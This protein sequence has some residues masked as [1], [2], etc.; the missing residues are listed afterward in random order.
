MVRCG[1]S[2]DL[3]TSD[4]INIDEDAGPLR[5]AISTV[6]LNR[7]KERFEKQCLRYLYVLVSC[8]TRRLA[9]LYKRSLRFFC[10]LDGNFCILPKYIYCKSH[11]YSVITF[12]GQARASGT[13]NEDC[14][15]PHFAA[16]CPHRCFSFDSRLS[17]G[18]E[19]QSD[20]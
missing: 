17:I 6:P 12:A 19:K 18:P 2:L 3:G 7:N 11:R 20:A 16:L 1:L 8:L 9:I 10:F 14:L 15:F 13:G 4:T 5:G